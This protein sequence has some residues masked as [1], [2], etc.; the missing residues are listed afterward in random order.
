MSSASSG[1]YQSRIFNFIHKQS[2]RFTKQCDRAFRRLQDI[3]W[4]AAVGSPFLLLFQS[5]SSA[6]KQLH[7]SVQQGKALLSSTDTQL[8]TPPA[9][10]TPIQQVLRS[11]D[12]LSSES[13]ISTSFPSKPEPLKNLLVSL[14]S[15][16]FKLELRSQNR[17]EKEDNSKFTRHSYVTTHHSQ[18]STLN[19]PPIQGIATQLSSRT[20]VL[21][22]SNEILDILTFQQQEQLQDE[23]IAAV[24]DYWRYQR[25]LG[26]NNRTLTGSVEGHKGRKD[27]NLKP[28]I[29][30]SLSPSPV[31]TF[32]DR[33]AAEVESN[34]LLPVS[35]VAI[36]LFS[37]LN[38]IGASLSKSK[39]SAIAT[40]D[41]SATQ[42]MKI[43]NLIRAAID[44]FFGSHDRTLEQNQQQSNSISGINQ[45][46]PESIPRKAIASTLQNLAQRS[47]LPSN[48]LSQQVQ[49]EKRSLS[50]IED[51]WLCES[52]LFGDVLDEIV[53]AQ[54]K[55]SKSK[56]IISGNKKTTRAL[57]P[58]RS[59]G[60]SLGKIVNSF[61]QFFLPPSPAS[62]IVKQQKINNGKVVEISP[63]SPPLFRSPQQDMTG[64]FSTSFSSPRT[65]IEAK[66]DWIETNAT[67]MGYV[68]HPLE[69]LL[70][71]L[72]SLMLWLEEMLLKIWQWL[73]HR[74]TGK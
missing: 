48:Q 70:A 16:R 2:R 45:N 34:H 38:Q 65:E 29:H 47:K 71:W 22:S 54:S 40:D 41:S 43:Q 60:Y 27:Q 14:V 30:N 4:V 21:V 51:P 53:T 35:S 44:Y 64:E 39:S 5:T 50:H 73:Q 23:I 69:Q 33:K 15:W 42:T 31:L 52:D 12:A 58:D 67:V 37:K 56:A 55:Q 57:P 59:S 24:A 32:L 74:I 36:A 63:K 10:D 11:L 19:H 49:P 66:P 6:T 7:S 3:N 68:K 9:V 26:H 72:D 18:L 62:E 28:K 13:A 1:R 20:L 46:L 17:A 61:R 8:Q 25:K